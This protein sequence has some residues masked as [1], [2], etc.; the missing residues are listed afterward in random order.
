MKPLLLALALAV[1]MAGCAQKVGCGTVLRLDGRI[2]AVK[3]D[4]GNVVEL[5]TSGSLAPGDRICIDFI[6]TFGKVVR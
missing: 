6:P 3:L 2:A 5:R 1:G 4:A